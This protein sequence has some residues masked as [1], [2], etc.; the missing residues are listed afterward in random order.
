MFLHA[1]Q[2]LTLTIKK[3]QFLSYRKCMICLSYY[4]YTQKLLGSH[5]DSINDNSHREESS[6]LDNCTCA[7]MIADTHK[8]TKSWYTQQCQASPTQ[9]WKQ[10]AACW[11]WERLPLWWLLLRLCAKTLAVGRLLTMPTGSQVSTYLKQACNWYRYT[12]QCTHPCILQ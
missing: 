9:P 11:V 1:L 6:L 3:A 10:A 8:R 2:H 12:S 5:K 4:A 7:S